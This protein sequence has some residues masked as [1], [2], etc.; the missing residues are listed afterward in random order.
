MHNNKNQCHV[1]Y[2]VMSGQDT[3]CQ[4]SSQQNSQREEHRIEEDNKDVKEDEKEEKEEGGKE[5][6]K[7]ANEDMVRDHS[8]NFMFVY[9]EACTSNL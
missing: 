3:H 9:F 1:K 7:E 6:E 4:R 8:N 2:S 5:D